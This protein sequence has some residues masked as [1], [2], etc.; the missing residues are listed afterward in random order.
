MAC[1]QKEC[2]RDHPYSV[3]PGDLEQ[4]H[5]EHEQI[6]VALRS[7]DA[8][9]ARSVI[10]AHLDRSRDLRLRAFAANPSEI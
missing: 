2:V 1:G 8:A 5:A 7:R 3:N 6:M 10:G 9:A 4:S